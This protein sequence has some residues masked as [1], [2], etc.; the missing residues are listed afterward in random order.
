MIKAIYPGTFDPLTKGHENVISRAQQLFGGIDVVVGY[1]PRKS[2][3]FSVE[4]RKELIKEATKGIPGVIVS[5]FQGLT[6]DYLKAN[7]SNVI[8]RGLRVISDFEFE[9]QMSLA[10]KKLYPDCEILYLMPGENYTYLNSSMVKEIAGLGGDVS[11]FV[12]GNV[13]QALKAKFSSPE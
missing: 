10:N 3:L 9:F 2:T 5:S 6:V 12:S 7:K 13:E 11:S 4:E 8:I 1:N